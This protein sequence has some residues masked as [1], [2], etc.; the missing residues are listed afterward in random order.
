MKLDTGAEVN[1]LP[2]A[3]YNKSSVK[4]PLQPTDVKLTAYGGTFLSPKGVCKLSCKIKGSQHILE[5]F[6]L[7]VDSKSILGLKD[8][9]ED[10]G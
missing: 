5:F 10:G 7:K 8:C 4:L 1:F 2:I 3:T 6:V 9:G